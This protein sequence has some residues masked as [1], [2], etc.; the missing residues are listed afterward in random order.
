MN[1]SKLDQVV[2][3][4]SGINAYRQPEEKKDKTNLFNIDDF[5]YYKNNFKSVDINTKE[6]N[7]QLEA[8]DIVL[9]MLTGESIII[10]EIDSSKVLTHNF[11]RLRS[12][13]LDCG[14]LFYLLN[15]D[16]SVLKQINRNKEGSSAIKRL[17]RK[18]LGEIEVNVVSEEDQQKIGQIY[19]DMR[20]LK[21]NM[22]EEANTLEQLTNKKL[23]EKIEENTFEYESMQ[24]NK[25]TI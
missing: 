1:K 14:Y 13:Q 25:Q 18:A 21:A 8:G 4:K 6:N 17:S 20:K 22:I 9:N 23:Y 16:E 24:S 5:E 19:L 3:I 11:L 2:E 15:G 12:S 7:N 10:G